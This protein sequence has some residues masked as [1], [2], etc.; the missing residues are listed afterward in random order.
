MKK[1]YIAPGL[2]DLRMVLHAGAAWITV[3]FKG[4]RACGYGE[5]S[6]SFATAD[7]ALQYLIEESPE[8]KSGRIF[9]SN[10]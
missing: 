5:Y 4:G 6:A 7:P 3:D 8:F 9:L 1:I 10:A 2:L